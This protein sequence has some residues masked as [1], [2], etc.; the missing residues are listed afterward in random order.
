MEIVLF[1]VLLCVITIRNLYY[2]RIIRRSIEE[3]DYK[4][5]RECLMK[6]GYWWVDLDSDR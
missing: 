3:K 1:V 2:Q 5:A 4:T 6:I